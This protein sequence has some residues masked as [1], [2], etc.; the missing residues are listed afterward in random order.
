MFRGLVSGLKK[1][2][3]SFVENIFG[4]SSSQTKLTAE[5]IIANLENALYR[6]DVGV[7][8]TKHLVSQVNA[9]RDELM[10]SAIDDSDA[11]QKL[12]TLLRSEMLRLFQTPAQKRAPIIRQLQ[13]K[14]Q[15]TVLMVVGVNGVGK[16]TTIGKLAYLY[17]NQHKRKIVVAAADTVRAAAVEQLEIW[18]QRNE[19]PVIARHA[20]SSSSSSSPS[21]SHASKS[22]AHLHADKSSVNIRQV[23]EKIS[24]EVVVHDAFQ[25]VIQQKKLSPEENNAPDLMI[26]DT[27][28]R[29]QTNQSSMDELQRISGACSKARRGAPDA[30]WIVLDATIGQ[31]SIDQAKEF[32]KRVQ[33]SGVIMTKLDGSARGGV[34]LGVAHT[35]KIPILYVGVGEKSEDLREFEAEAFVDSILDY[36]TNTT[37][38]TTEEESN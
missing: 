27:A 14:H 8:T 36:H 18:G 7:T 12:R 28:G 6:S 5:Q 10:K 13:S 37:A 9:K 15:P 24:P 38:E 22:K 26:V 4:G 29:L 34:I 33:V 23:Y 25:Y 2:T 11:V 1:T 20:Q 3:Q 32:T 17:K 30:V 19:I 21:T 31:N 16:T 35:L